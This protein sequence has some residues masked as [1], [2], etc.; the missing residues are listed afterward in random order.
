MPFAPPA[1][2]VSNTWASSA[3][4]LLAC[5]SL[6][7]CGLQSHGAGRS[8]AADQTSRTA[9]DN[10]GAEAGYLPPPRLLSVVRSPS[11][12]MLM[13]SAAPQA[14]VELLAPEGETMTVQANAAGAWR[15]TL[16]AVTRP[17]M[18]ALEDRLKDPAP[19]GRVVHSEGALIL[20][21][22]SGPPALLVRAGAGAL[23]F[24]ARAVRPSLD[25]LDYDPGGFS[26]AAGRARP[27]A[28]VRLMMDGVLAGVGQADSGGR[29][30]ILAPNRRLTF[31]THMALVQ[32]ADGQDERSFTIDPPDSTL[33]TYYKV[34]PIPGGWRL[35]WALTGGGVQTTLVFIPA[36]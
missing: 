23:V 14:K 21:P 7:G 22:H 25:A 4:I 3:L 32:S 34:D 19:T 24:A 20:I 6:C 26:A 35:E 28:S 16:P 29:F 10:D 27:G 31:G 8:G 13:G 36:G 12:V 17:R 30:S 33:T 18:F 5:A 1:I 2:S 9:I 15:L 11:A